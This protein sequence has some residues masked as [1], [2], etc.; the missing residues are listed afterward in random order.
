MQTL[1]H[2]LTGAYGSVSAELTSLHFGPGGGPK[3]YIQAALHADEVPAML[4][5][6]SLRRRLLQLERDGLLRGEVVLVPAANPLGLAQVLSER[7]YGRF[8]LGTGT[9]FNR[10]FAHFHEALKQQLEGRLGDDGDANVRQI[11]AALLELAAQLPALSDVATLKKTLLSLAIDADVVLDLHCDNEAAMHVYTGT[12]LCDAVAP[13]AGL[14]DAKALLHTRVSGGEPFDEACS[15]LWWELQAHFGARH[16]VPLACVAATVEL[17]GETAVDYISAERDALAI[18]R[19]LALR[20]LVDLPD[21]IPAAA[22]CA[23]SPLEGCARLH[24]PH[25]GVLVYLRELGEPVRVGDAVADL[26]DP[27]SGHT[28]P[29]RSEAAGIFFGRLSHR[30]VSRGMSVGKVAGQIPFRSGKLLSL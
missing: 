17:R 28:T 7:P 30:Y 15:R 5:A 26:I 19:F 18:V 2:P 1:K 9:N 3:A 22:A 20:G 14:L 16:P 11:R 23:P 21:P 29:I 6:Q 4:V 12:P 24:A 27:V 25:A 13:L 10:D 8:D